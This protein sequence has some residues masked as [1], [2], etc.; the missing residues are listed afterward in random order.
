MTN[1]IQEEVKTTI[2][3]FNSFFSLHFFNIQF[4]CTTGDNAIV[5]CLCTIAHL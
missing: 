1:E 5:D 4:S 2:F 3:A